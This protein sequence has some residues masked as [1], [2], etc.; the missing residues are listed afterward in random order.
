MNDPVRFALQSSGVI[1]SFDV[2]AFRH[3]P[4]ANSPW[5]P[6]FDECNVMKCVAS[7]RNTPPNDSVT[8]RRRFGGGGGG[9]KLLRVLMGRPK[10]PHRI[11]AGALPSEIPGISS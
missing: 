2:P 5:Q 11:Q 3:A 8:P 10:L 9:G 6:Y 1:Y 7:S 4:S